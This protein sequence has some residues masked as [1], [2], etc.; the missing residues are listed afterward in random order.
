M[1]AHI[2]QKILN[3]LILLVRSPILVIFCKLGHLSVS[4]FIQDLVRL[5]HPEHV[6]RLVVMNR[7]VLHTLSP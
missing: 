7:L 5:L 6:E 1:D 2:L 4:Y 3:V